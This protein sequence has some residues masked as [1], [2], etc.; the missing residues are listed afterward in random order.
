MA[1]GM[2]LFAEARGRR[3]RGE[4]RGPG[5]YYKMPERSTYWARRS[6]SSAEAI[7]H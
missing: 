7:P 3:W 5:V 1:T 2:G 6:S 4:A